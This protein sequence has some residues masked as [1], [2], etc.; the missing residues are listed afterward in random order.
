M[1]ACLISHGNMLHVVS[2]LQFMVARGWDVHWLQIAA[3]QYTVPGVTAH[4]LY[5][6]E[7]Q[8]LSLLGKLT[9]LRAGWRARI[10][11]RHLQPDLVWPHYVSSGGLVAWLSG[12]PE[13]C[14]TI[15]GSD[16]LERSRTLLGRFLLRRIL[17]RARLVNPV[18]EHMQ[19]VLLQLGVPREKIFCM[20]HGI[21]LAYY[22]FRPGPTGPGGI[23]RLVCTRTFNSTLYDIPTLLHAVALLKAS[24]LPCRLTLA[25]TGP[26]EPDLRRLAGILGIDKEVTF[27]G[28]YRREELGEIFAAHDL[29]IS[30]SLWDGTSLSLLEAMACGIL[31]VVTDIP[32]NSSLIKDGENGYLFAAG[33]PAA[34]AAKIKQ[35]VGIGDRRTDWL[36]NNRKIVEHRGDLNR[37]LELLMTHVEETMS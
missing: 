22:P 3:G 12:W 29:Y 15:H 7:E 9:Y 6:S 37:N 11:L 17:A 23:I 4:R 27:G 32:A 34:L 24:G 30:P 16:L 35:A 36:R 18:A 14:V 8:T 25:A 2:R 26:L 1:K 13:Y 5:D 28:G 31:P 19:A 20:T 21:A 10:L 33:D